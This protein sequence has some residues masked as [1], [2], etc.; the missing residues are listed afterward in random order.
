[1]GATYCVFVIMHFLILA[2]KVCLNANLYTLA[3]SGGGGGG[4]GVQAGGGG[5]KGCKR[6]GGCKPALN[7]I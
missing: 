3:D 6:E 7:H 1:M 4:E 5:G 2:Y